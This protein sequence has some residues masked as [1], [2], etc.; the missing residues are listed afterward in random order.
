MGAWE[1]KNGKYL[2]IIYNSKTTNSRSIQ[3]IRRKECISDKFAV[4]HKRMFS[5]VLLMPIEILKILRIEVKDMRV[6]LYMTILAKIILTDCCC[7]CCC[8]QGIPKFM[9]LLYLKF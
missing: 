8:V 1:E 9:D 7:S 6:K 4:K 2:L 5:A 3:C